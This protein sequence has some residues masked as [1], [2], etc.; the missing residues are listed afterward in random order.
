MI[1]KEKAEELVIK[2]YQ[3]LPASKEAEK[4]KEHLYYN[5]YNAAKQCALI[6]VDEMLTHV[7][8]MDD[9]AAINYWQEVK[10]E[11]ENL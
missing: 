4:D 1:P 10:T 8:M 2:M 7:E 5:Q 9:N 11:I 6:A 3:P